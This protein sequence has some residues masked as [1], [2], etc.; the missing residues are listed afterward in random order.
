MGENPP[1]PQEV[2]EVLRLLDI[3]GG[4]EGSGAE[5][6]AGV[7]AEAEIESVHSKLRSASKYMES[8][9]GKADAK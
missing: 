3:P 9:Q 1:S 8:L 2:R 4:E 6:E 5:A 7:E